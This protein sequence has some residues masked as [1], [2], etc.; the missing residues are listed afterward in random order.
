M[1]HFQLVIVALVQSM[2]GFDIEMLVSLVVYVQQ[3][4]QSM[5]DGVPW[6]IYNLRPDD[7]SLR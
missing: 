1:F 2:S 6:L 3:R 5:V 7:H 4:L